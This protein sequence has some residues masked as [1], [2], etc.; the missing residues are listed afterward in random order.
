MCLL[1][2]S[3]GLASKNVITTRSEQSHVLIRLSCFLYLP[4]YMLLVRR[5]YIF[6]SS[7]CECWTGEIINMFPPLW[8]SSDEM[9]LLAPLWSISDIS[10]SKLLSGIPVTMNGG[11]LCRAFVDRTVQLNK[12]NLY[13]EPERAL[14][15][16]HVCSRSK[17]TWQ[18]LVTP[19]PLWRFV[20]FNKAIIVS[21][22]PNRN[23]Y[24]NKYLC[25]VIFGQKL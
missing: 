10:S 22:T 24:F 23:N 6:R 13:E 3:R 5:I 7:Q 18:C 21:I 17:W 15:S 12:S 2:Q 19:T 25:A 4:Y 14:S 11:A 8:A 9:K 16:S 1:E 20:I